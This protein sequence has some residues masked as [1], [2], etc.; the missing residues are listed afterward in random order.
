MATRL[1]SGK[2][3]YQP[4]EHCSSSSSTGMHTT[5][6]VEESHWFNHSREPLDNCP[7]ENQM[8]AFSHSFSLL[9][10]EHSFGQEKMYQLPVS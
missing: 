3:M 8:L 1:A 4:N 5:G 9:D 6:T 2:D 10:V 7:L